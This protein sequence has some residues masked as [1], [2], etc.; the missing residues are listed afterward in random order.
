MIESADKFQG[1]EMGW[2]WPL[3]WNIKKIS[4]LLRP[5]DFLKNDEG[6]TRK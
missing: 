5:G 1:E 3:A 6:E 4:Q 2:P